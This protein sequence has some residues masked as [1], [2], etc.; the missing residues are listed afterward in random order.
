MRAVYFFQLLYKSLKLMLY[1]NTVHCNLYE[2]WNPLLRFNWLAVIYPFLPF[3]F[4]RLSG[5]P[6]HLELTLIVFAFNNQVQF[7]LFP[8]RN[9]LIGDCWINAQTCPDCPNWYEVWSGSN[10]VRYMMSTNAHTHINLNMFF[11]TRC[12]RLR[13]SFLTQVTG[14]WYICW[15]YL[16]TSWPARLRPRNK[17]IS[18]E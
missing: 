14:T 16:L 9:K 4:M 1:W 6:P 8:K 3:W 11:W 10:D 17:I 2:V 7:D 15:Y 12:L 5:F 18:L 13:K